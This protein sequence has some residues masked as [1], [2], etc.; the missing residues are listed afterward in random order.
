MWFRVFSLSTT[1]PEP[2]ALLEHFERKGLK[3]EGHFKGDDLGWFKVELV[4]PE[5]AATLTMDRYLV[6]EDD[7]RDDL[8]AWAAW[9]ETFE[10]DPTAARLMQHVVSTSQLFTLDCP[11]DRAEQFPVGTFCQD[12]C[13]YLAQ[14]TQGVYQIDTS[15]FFAP[16]GRRLVKE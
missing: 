13:R 12:L 2:A 3:V 1:A 16:D 4:L 6:K 5:G 10:D 8:N 14:Q 15:G 11:R 9:L 7:V